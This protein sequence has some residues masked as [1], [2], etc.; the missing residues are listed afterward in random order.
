MTSRTRREFLEESM[1]ATAAAVASTVSGDS[2]SASW[3]ESPSPNERLGVVVMGVRG[4]GKTH[5]GV[6]S[7]RRDTEVLYVCDVDSDVGGRRIDE[8]SRRQRGRRPRLVDDLRIALAD[9]RVDIVS[10]A[11]PNHWHALAG[12]WSMQA[13]KDVYVE[14]PVSH[15]VAEGRNLVQ[16]SRKHRRIC[17]AGFQARSNPGMIEAMRFAHS[18]GIG[19]LVAARAISWRRTTP[20]QRVTHPTTTSINRELWMGPVI[21]SASRSPKIHFGWQQQWDYGNG[22]LGQDGLQPL[23][24]GR[25]ALGKDHWCGNVASYG[26][27]WF[28][29]PTPDAP[30]LQVAVYDLSGQSLVLESRVGP[31]SVVPRSQSAVIVSGTQG[32]LVLSSFKSGVAFDLEGNKV[33]EFSGGGGNQW[34]FGNFIQAVRSRRLRDLNADIEQGHRSSSLC[35]LGNI[36]YRLGHTVS[37]SQAMTELCTPQSRHNP[38]AWDSAVQRLVERGLGTTGKEVQLGPVLEFDSQS[39]RFIDHPFADRYLSR[40]YK[41]EFATEV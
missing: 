8:L 28:A 40:R 11:A 32:Y 2:A 4:R 23:D 27:S 31:K 3:L 30:D 12:I 38:I 18:G 25:W 1:L 14:R 33:C 15:N 21:A 7:G 16:A 39:E 10:I 26:C 20:R 5:L 41:S 19:K 35:H 22:L 6:F 34:H 36:A 24:L 37:R 13:G 9:P 29:K 17:Q